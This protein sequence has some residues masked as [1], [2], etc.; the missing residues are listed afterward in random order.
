MEK[1]FLLF[2]FKK[3]FIIFFFTF[4]Y[5]QSKDVIIHIFYFIF[6]FGLETES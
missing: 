6:F 1:L 4:I 2:L 5:D 3:I